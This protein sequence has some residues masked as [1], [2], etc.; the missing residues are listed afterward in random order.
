MAGRPWG[1]S[2]KCILF[3]AHSGQRLKSPFGVSWWLDQQWPWRTACAQGLSFPP[4][5][6]LRAKGTFKWCTAMS[7]LNTSGT[8]RGW[9]RRK[10]KRGGK[11]LAQFL[12]PTPNHTPL[13]GSGLYFVLHQQ[14]PWRQPSSL[15]EQ[16]LR[17]VSMTHCHTLSSPPMP[18]SLSFSLEQIRAVSPQVAAVASLWS[19]SEHLDISLCT[20]R[21][22]VQLSQPWEC[23]L[24]GFPPWSTQ[25]FSLH[26]VGPR[27][28]WGEEAGSRK[29]R[30]GSD[31]SWD[32][33][34]LFGLEFFALVLM[35][36]ILGSC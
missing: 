32:D 4:A 7:W 31:F 11:L 17:E 25:K 19:A 6:L 12:V 29:C 5:P 23:F 20:L 10:S 22:P 3:S 8:G 33:D 36:G 21:I 2:G 1:H 9:E 26:D 24:V 30:S 14:S 27:L 35:A 15:Q 18:F 16:H 28:G 13:P 34:I